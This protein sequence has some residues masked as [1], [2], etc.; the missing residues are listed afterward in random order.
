MT[1]EQEKLAAARR[2]KEEDRLR[3]L[4]SRPPTGKGGEGGQGGK[5]R[6]GKDSKGANKGQSGDSGKGKGNQGGRDDNKSG[7]QKKNEK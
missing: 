6:K 1:E 4:M 7:W 5:T 3:S 2:A